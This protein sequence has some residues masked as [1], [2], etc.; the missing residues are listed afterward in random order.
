FWWSSRTLTNGVCCRFLRI[1]EAIE[2]ITLVDNANECI[3]LDIKCDSSMNQQNFGGQSCINRIS[4][5]I[6]PEYSTLRKPLTWLCIDLR[7]A[8]FCPNKSH[9][10]KLYVKRG[11]K[12]IVCWNKPDFKKKS[13]IEKIKV[14]QARE[15]I[16]SSRKDVQQNKKKYAEKSSQSSFGNEQKV[17][18]RKQHPELN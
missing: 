5:E 16:D 9:V 14:C 3:N 1:L 10:C 17:G 13:V 6:V 4:N 11:H 8:Q 12:E 2:K 7:F 15:S 18:G